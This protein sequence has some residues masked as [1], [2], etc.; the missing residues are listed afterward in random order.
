MGRIHL[1]WIFLACPFGVLAYTI[2]PTTSP[3]TTY[4]TMTGPPPTYTTMTGPPPT[5]TTMTGPPPTYTTQQYP[6]VNAYQKR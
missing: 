6:F 4:T 5:Y 1:I 3:P 2:P